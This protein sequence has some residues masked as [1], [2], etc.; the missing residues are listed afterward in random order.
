MRSFGY[1]L[2]LGHPEDDS[3]KNDDNFK[4]DD[5]FKSDDGFMYSA[6]LAYLCG[7]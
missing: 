4:G 3:F 1:A 2:A 5:R 6:K 7:V